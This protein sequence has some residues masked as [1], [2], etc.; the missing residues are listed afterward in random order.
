V[1]YKESPNRR[2]RAQLHAYI[3]G[4]SA[5][6]D[7]SLSEGVLIYISRETF[8]MK[9]FHVEFE[10]EFW[11]GTVKSWANTHTEYRLDGEL[12][13]A[14]PEADWECE[15]CSYRQ[16]CGKGDGPHANMSPRGFLPNTESYPRGKVREYLDTHDEAKLT[17]SLAR[18]YPDLADEYAIHLWECPSCS[19]SF[20]R[21]NLP[22]EPGPERHPLCPHC[23]RSD[24]LVELRLSTPADGEV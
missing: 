7:V 15:Y 2:H 24:T 21:E 22:V 23:A 16:R 1:E 10:S 18:K 3:A 11:E 17:P 8:D 4:L 13:P 20:R 9:V 14:Q 5:E 12:P 6:Y 19:T